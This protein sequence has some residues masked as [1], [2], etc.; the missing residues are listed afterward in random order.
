MSADQQAYLQLQ[1]EAMR[2]QLAQQLA[3]TGTQLMS[4]ATANL[5]LEGQLY[6]ELMQQQIA[7]DQQ[8]SSSITGFVQA[9]AYSSV[10][11]NR[12]IQVVQ[13]A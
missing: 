3:Q 2:G 12:P 4:Q 8:L 5:G 10:M 9:M 6:G 11:A 13:H 7:N 1:T